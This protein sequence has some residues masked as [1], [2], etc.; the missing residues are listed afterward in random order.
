M[1]KSK[2][3]VSPKKKVVA[4][5]N[6]N[7]NTTTVVAP[8][9]KLQPTRS[10]KKTSSVAMPKES[11]IFGKQNYI[12]MAAGF[13]LILLGML[14]MSGGNMPSPEVWDEGII[15]STRRTVIA[16]FVMLAG[17]ALEVYAIFKK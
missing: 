13:G 14:L 5:S 6:K 7:S 16:P 9:K 10:R 11:L 17:L 4:S 2:R 12:L 3:K 8:K 1:S 15:Y